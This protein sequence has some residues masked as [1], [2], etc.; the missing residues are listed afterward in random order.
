MLPGTGC[1]AL[2]RHGAADEACVRAS[3]AGVL[4]LPPFYYKGV[5]EDGLYRS[6][7]EVIE[8]VGDPNLRIYLYHIP[9]VSG[10]GVP[11]AVIER[12]FREYPSM[13]AGIKDSAGDWRILKR[14][15][16]RFEGP[17]LTCLSG[18]SHSCWQ[19][20]KTAGPD[21]FPRLLT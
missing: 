3:C 20:C 14:F 5:S 19:I 18:V 12:L 16:M 15:S 6:Y 8:R 9:Q 21:A 10:V 17:A 13:V 1:C 11:L 2:V 4:M 7:A